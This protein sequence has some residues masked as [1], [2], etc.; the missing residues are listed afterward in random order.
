MEEFVEYIRGHTCPVC[1]GCNFYCADCVDPRLD[2]LIAIANAARAFVAERAPELATMERDGVSEWAAYL[3][4]RAYELAPLA[5][6]L[7]ELDG[8]GSGS[9]TKSRHSREGVS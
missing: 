9:T 5:A 3:E 7:N 6:A 1:G 2:T 8:A 4:L